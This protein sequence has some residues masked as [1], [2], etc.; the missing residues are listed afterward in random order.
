MHSDPL[1]N[2]YYHLL[3]LGGVGQEEEAFTGLR[4]EGITTQNVF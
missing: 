1:N 4:S 2:V 3:H